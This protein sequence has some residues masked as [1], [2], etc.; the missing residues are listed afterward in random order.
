MEYEAD[1]NKDLIEKLMDNCL[2][3]ARDILK[4]MEE[5]NYYYYDIHH[6]TRIKKYEC[7]K[8]RKKIKTIEEALRNRDYRE[9]D[10]YLINDDEYI[11]QELECEI[12]ALI[13]VLREKIP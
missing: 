6:S 5:N 8:L 3:M 9:N 7:G 1:M 10:D 13:N 11:K 12:P 2:P 4:L